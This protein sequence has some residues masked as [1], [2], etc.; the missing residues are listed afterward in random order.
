MKPPKKIG[1][2]AT[3]EELEEYQEDRTKYELFVTN[4]IKS[5]SGLSRDIDLLIFLAEKY[6]P[7]LQ[8]KKKVGAKTK[9]DDHLNTVIA[10]EIDSLKKV[11]GTRKNAIEQLISDPLWAFLIKN[12]KDPFS[13]FD[14]ADKAGHKKNHIFNVYRD[15]RQYAIETNSLDEYKKEIAWEIKNASRKD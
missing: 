10:V 6:H 2:L 3:Q 9:W 4:F 15:A 7:K 5:E 13:L 12:S 11:C 8:K 14:K 1:L